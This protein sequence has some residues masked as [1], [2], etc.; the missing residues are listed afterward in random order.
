LFKRVAVVS[1][2]FVCLSIPAGAQTIYGLFQI[3]VGDG[4]TRQIGTLDPTTGGVGLIGSATSID[5]DP[6][7]IGTG[8]TAIAVADD[9]YYFVGTDQGD[10]LS[11]V[12]TVDNDTGATLASH[13]LGTYSAGATQ[14][15]WYEESTSTIWG[16]FSG[17]SGE[18]ILAAINPADGTVDMPINAD[19]SG[20]PLST[21][22]GVFTGDSD[23]NRVFV[24]GTPD[25]DDPMLYEVSTSDGSVPPWIL[26]GYDENSVVGIEWDAVSDPA[27]LWMLVFRGTG[28]QLARYDFDEGETLLAPEEI[29]FGDPVGTNQGMTAIDDDSG[30]FFFIGK[31]SGLPWSI[32]TLTLPDGAATSQAIGG[33]PIQIGAWAGIE[34]SPGPDLSL[35]K[36][37]NVAGSVVPGDTITY[38]LTA[39]NAAGAGTAGGVVLS[40]T[41]PAETSFSAGAS[42]PGWVC[43][44][45]GSA[46]STCTNNL[47]DIVS[48]TNTMVDFAVVIDASVSPTL[49][50]IDNTAT[51]SATNTTTDANAMEST[52]I[53]AAAVLALTKD[54][55]G[56]STTP[57]STVVYSLTASNTGNA[58]ALGTV[59]SDTVPANTVFASGASTAGWSCADG[60]PAGS[61][62]TFTLGS[63][64][65]GS[66]TA[67]SFAV[68]VIASVPAGTTEITNAA[69]LDSSNPAGA[70]AADST[71]VVA[72]PALGLSKTDSGASAVPGT[73][74]SYDLGYSNTGDEDAA[75]TVLEETVP[76]QT[77]FNPAAS[78]A[79]WVC[80]P[81]GSA[82]STCT[83][84]LGTLGGGASDVATFAV[85]VDDPVLAGTTEIANSATLNA[86][87]AP[88]P[89]MASDTSIVVADPDLVLSKSDGDIST[90]PGRTLSYFLVYGNEGNENAADT[91]LT[92]T[93]PDNTSF[94][95]KS[96]S[97][98]WVCTP[99]ILAGATC[100]LDIGDLSGGESDLAVFAVLVD[101]PVPAG[102][103]EIVNSAIVDASN[104]PAP[105][106]GGDTT[107]VLADPEL[108]L[109]KDDGG[110]TAA[111]GDVIIYTL[112]YGNDGDQEA[113]DLLLTETVP[114][115]TA[116]DAAGSTA[117]WVCV[118]DGSAGSSCDLDVGNLAGGGATGSAAFAVRVDDPFPTGSTEVSNDAG[119]SASNA[120]TSAGAS[121]TTPVDVRLDIAISKEDE[122]VPTRPGGTIAFSL[123]WENLGTQSAAGV[124]IS[125]TVPTAATFNS[126]GSTAG[127]VCVP[128]TG[129]GSTCTFAVGDAAAGAMGV[130]T[131]A[132]T[133]DDPV[134][135]GLTAIEN[136]V[137]IADDGS[138]GADID[139]ANNTDMTSTAIDDSPPVVLLVDASPSIGGIGSCSQLDAQV[140]RLAVEFEDVFSGVVDPD[141]LA[142]YMIVAAGADHDLSTTECGPVFGD[143]V[144]IPINQITITGVPTNPTATLELSSPLGNG[145]ALILV[146]DS[147][148][149]LAGNPLD[150]DGDGEPGGDLGLRFRVDVGNEFANAHLDDC[151]DAP[152]ALAPWQDNSTAPNSVGTTL[153]Q[154]LHDS[155]LS[156]SIEIDS[157]DGQSTRVGQCVPAVGSQRR[158]LTAWARIDA[159]TTADVSV[160][161]VCQFSN[162]PDCTGIGSED[163]VLGSIEL[164]SSPVP[165]W[166][167]GSGGVMAPSWAVSA[168]CGIAAV[169]DSS[170]PFHI[171]VDALF[172]GDQLFADGFELGDTSAWSATSN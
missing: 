101:D 107:P 162:Q 154:D 156:G 15:L 67:V 169:A 11:K 110:I 36:D 96:S 111:P 83:L 34:V 119:V 163:T 151:T 159:A 88:A 172:V 75:L 38:T 122:G 18:R 9:V 136:S 37:D 102:V 40:E 92:E 165:E 61:L 139:P 168:F 14:G 29:D 133:V 149:D 85:T 71:P 81:D 19:I 171:Y 164:V 44:P 28:R 134:T 3:P 145:I 1:V 129:A 118:P 87:N 5:S 89:A 125:E 27:T 155:S 31:P 100:V 128:D 13:T 135:G 91:T 95:F 4:G 124:E 152:I 55:G 60:A 144:E 70:M 166:Q 105:A 137:S 157:S 104:A 117:G 170:Q 2:L 77:T 84:D 63:F 141:H 131:F 106:N 140:D 64:E 113:L 21:S 7:A 153:D 50:S 138:L 59:L 12:Y 74:L 45:D 123:T 52:P 143:D 20:G 160:D 132:V 69:S 93:V 33:D 94:F 46:G 90:R 98:G 53:T 72:D 142:S 121:D 65:G 79:G 42:D 51:L 80:V 120:P 24:I 58:D 112:T 68:T 41:V 25:G 30:Q 73:T 26:E 103:S 146:C 116:F 86:S 126:A 6:I 49:S 147:I 150:G 48:G 167:I 76:L 8:I 109:G 82:G 39:S 130:V 10:S 114:A 66:M 47:A 158:W 43:A 62:C 17:G 35:T 54:D 108:T 148:R 56:I 161:L 127:W 97:P 16:L 32:Y 78:T 23:N 57:G 99:D 115:N 22:G